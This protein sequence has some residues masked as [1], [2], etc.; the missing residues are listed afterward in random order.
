MR[1][2]DCA[3]QDNRDTVDSER[4]EA[5]KN[6]GRRKARVPRGELAKKRDP[7]PVEAEAVGRAVGVAAANRVALSLDISQGSRPYQSH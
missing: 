6:R 3:G 2:I 1:G 4:A 5:R 7:L